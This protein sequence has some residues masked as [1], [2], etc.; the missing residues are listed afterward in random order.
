MHFGAR[1]TFEYLYF[2]NAVMCF[3]VVHFVYFAVIAKS[4]GDVLCTLGPGEC[5]AFYFKR[6]EMCPAFLCTL[7]PRVLFV[8]SMVIC[9][10]LLCLQKCKICT[11][12]TGKFARISTKVNTSS[13]APLSNHQPSYRMFEMY[14]SRLIKS[15]IDNTGL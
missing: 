10:A 12:L 9:A 5:F 8:A 1:C 7:R 11:V 14:T 6:M 3:Q 15:L 13:C 4:F 2:A